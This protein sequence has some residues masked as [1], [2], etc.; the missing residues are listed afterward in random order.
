MDGANISIKIE[1]MNKS[2]DALQRIYG[3][4]VEYKDDKNVKIVMDSTCDV[5]TGV[6]D[7]QFATWTALDDNVAIAEDP[8]ELIIQMDTITFE[9]GFCDE[10]YLVVQDEVMTIIDIAETISDIIEER[11]NRDN[12]LSSNVMESVK[13]TNSTYEYNSTSYSSTAI[14][15]EIATKPIID[16]VSVKLLVFVSIYVMLDV[17]TEFLNHTDGSLFGSNTNDSTTNDIYASDVVINITFKLFWLQYLLSSC[18]TT[19]LTGKT[20]AAVD[21]TLDNDTYDESEPQD[22][23]S[24]I[25]NKHISDNNVYV[26]ETEDEEQEEG[27][28]QR[29]EES[30]RRY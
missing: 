23:I 17:L 25:A 2:G 5:L 27:E 29:V 19:A 10:E 8:T 20:I 15:G 28:Q 30:M 3:L 24:S 21:H 12:M 13:D 6:D 16:S 22:V 11:Y 4:F 9:S 26:P 18:A 14:T 1:Q 7:A